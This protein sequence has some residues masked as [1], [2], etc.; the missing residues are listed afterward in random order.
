M[1]AF[2]NV[3]CNKASI[4]GAYLSNHTLQ[5]I[6]YEDGEESLL[7]EPLRLL[8]GLNRNNTKREAARQKILQFHICK[9]NGADLEA[10]VGMELNVLPVAMAWIGRDDVGRSA[11]YQL[12]RTLPSLFST[13]G[14]QGSAGLKRKRA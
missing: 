13:N 6:C 9:N 5:M 4:E 2:C 1:E 11:I 8:L 7:P 12:C 14:K 10:F 3:L